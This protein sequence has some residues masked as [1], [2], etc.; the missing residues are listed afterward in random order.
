M[1]DG[2][3]NFG[4]KVRARLEAL[5]RNQAWL[6]E[7]IGTSPSQLSKWLND[8]NQPGHPFLLRLSNVL[9]L[10]INFLIDD[11]MDEE[12]RRFSLGED[13]DS[14]MIMRFM[15]HLGPA[16]VVKLIMKGNLKPEPERV[17]IHDRQTYGETNKTRPS[18]QGGRRAG[19]EK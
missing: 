16:E 11:S 12:P 3:K 13:V 4:D 6:S 9:G 2:L 5:D 17:V 10:P 14:Q 18:A 8:G 15:E 19:G 1:A 7:Q